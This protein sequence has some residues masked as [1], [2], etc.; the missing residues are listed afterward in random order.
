MFLSL[1]IKL[2]MLAQNVT[3]D[4]FGK[5]EGYGPKV[6]MSNP[7]AG[8]SALLSTAINITLIIGGI[9]VLAYGLWG[10]IEFITS[11]GEQEKVT[12]A[13][14]KITYA[15]TGAVLLIV[16]LAVFGVLAGNVLGI[17][18]KNAA[19]DW[20]FDIPYMAP[21]CKNAGG[22]CVQDSD[23]CSGLKCKTSNPTAPATCQ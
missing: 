20:V 6:G 22:S 17:V 19:G 14:D 7:A 15:F 9:L 5:I 16:V 12:K 21:I 4:P 13:R 8:F 3:P 10:A 1:G 11:G 18:K 2:Y 23:C